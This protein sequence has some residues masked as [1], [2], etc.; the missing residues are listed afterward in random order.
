MGEEV[1]RTPDEGGS[2]YQIR[3]RDIKG[4]LIIIRQ[5]G[6]KFLKL[7]DTACRLIVTEARRRS[8]ILYTCRALNKMG[9][10]V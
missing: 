7:K 4:V 9:K 8:V 10:V 6:E 5:Q 3:D 1:K 2:M